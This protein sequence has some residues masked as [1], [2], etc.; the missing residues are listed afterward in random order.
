MEE[1]IKTETNED[2]KTKI[3]HDNLK[4]RAA[5]KSKTKEIN[6]KGMKENSTSGLKNATDKANSK[7]LPRVK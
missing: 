5:D 4:N 6:G 1:V 7:V 3:E 2:Y